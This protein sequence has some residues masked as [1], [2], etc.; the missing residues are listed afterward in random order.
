VLLFEKGVELLHIAKREIGSEINHLDDETRKWFQEKSTTLRHQ[1]DTRMFFGKRMIFTEGESDTTFLTEIALNFADEDKSLDINTENVIIVNVDGKYNFPKYRRL[2]NSLD[3][4]HVI[5]GD[6][7]VLGESRND[8]KAIFESC[9]LITANGI[10]END[11]KV[12]VIKNGKLETL[13]EELD[14]DLYLKT[15]HRLEANFGKDNVPKSIMASEY[16]KEIMNTKPEA[17][18]SIRELL[19]KIIMFQ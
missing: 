4:P 12:F 2:A 5:L 1:I 8:M 19:R 9:S 18:F 16:V 11:N 3:I 17:L 10:E 13:M 14:A 6:K 15:R 7:D